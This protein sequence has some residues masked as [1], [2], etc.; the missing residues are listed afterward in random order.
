MKKVRDYFF[1]GLTGLFFSGCL[2]AADPTLRW[3]CSAVQTTNLYKNKVT[4]QTLNCDGYY[5]NQP[6]LK[7]LNINVIYAPLNDPEIKFMPHQAATSNQLAKLP[8]IANGINTPYNVVAGINGGY[9]YRNDVNKFKDN[10][11]FYKTF[12]P[13]KPTDS[14]G[15]SLLQHDGSNFAKNCAFWPN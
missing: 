12:T 9:F 14:M 11:C 3:N 1:V 2:H 7:S 10:I 5:N 15:D 4:W 13:P 8:D 6:L